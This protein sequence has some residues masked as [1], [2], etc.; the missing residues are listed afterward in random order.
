M[1]C[2]GTVTLEQE[3]KHGNA[4]RYGVAGFAVTP[5]A[6]ATFVQVP[7]WARGRRRL[8]A[9][10]TLT[11]SAVTRPRS[12]RTK[13]LGGQTTKSLVL[14]LRRPPPVAG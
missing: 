10:G 2:R 9:Y 11:L 12:P 5:G 8:A 6:A 1:V 14:R 4:R 13:G 7:L 3:D